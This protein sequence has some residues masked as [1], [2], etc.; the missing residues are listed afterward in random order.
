M[1][2]IYQQIL[3]DDITVLFNVYWLSYELVK[4]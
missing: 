4:P 3:V 2:G 1:L